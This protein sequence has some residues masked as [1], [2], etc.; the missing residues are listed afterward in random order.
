MVPPVIPPWTDFYTAD[1]LAAA[2]KIFQ[3]Y[4]DNDEYM[5]HARD[6]PDIANLFSL[7]RR[8]MLPTNEEFKDKRRRK[9]Q[10]KKEHDSEILA[11]AGIRQMRKVKMVGYLGGSVD[12]PMPPRI[13]T[14]EAN[15]A[16]AAE[17]DQKLIP[18]I[19]AV[20][21]VV[22]EDVQKENPIEEG[23]ADAKDGALPAPRRLMYHRSCHVCGTLFRDLHH[24]YDQMCPSCAEFNFKKRFSTADMHGRVC[25][26]TGARV[27]IGYAIALK[28]LRMG[29]TVLVTTRFPHDAA[30]RF[31][32][33]PDFEAFT[34]RLAVYGLDFRDIPMLHHFCRHVQERYSR[35]DVIIN[36]AAQTVRKPPAYYEHLIAGEAG[37]IS[38]QVRSIV[39]VVDVYRARHGG[40]VFGHGGGAALTSAEAAEVEA[41]TTTDGSPEKV[42]LGVALAA[43]Q[44][45]AHLQDVNV[46]AALSQLAV[47][48]SDTQVSKVQEFP[49]GL[50]DRDDQQL[51][52]RRENSW[53]MELGD[54]SSVEMMEC[55]VINTFAPWVLISE[56]KPLMARTGRLDGAVGDF[57]KFIVNVSAMEGQFYRN[58]TVFH[59][60]TNM[61]KAALNMMTRTASAG[62]AAINIFMTAV[63]TGWITD[64]NP[65]DQWHK[66]EQAPPPLDEWDAAM[67]VLDPVL[68]GVRGEEKLW[69]CFLKN[70]RSTRW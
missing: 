9:K 65:V 52:L 20:E 41:T 22:M 46:S 4:V 35:L 3:L 53:T 5:R 48:E 7:A 49:P 42:G 18:E 47:L 14:S 12:I 59:P 6:N 24:F 21:D 31:A 38:E 11:V 57:D 13:G 45:T 43:K 2:T 60:H 8:A 67:R 64:E 27:K 63:D 50:Y 15:E 30:N 36:N 55:H 1:E 56:L 23:G 32:R 29:A 25:I 51:D 68:V 10:A 28:L 34:G 39:D 33:E 54:I 37:G 58:K 66:R 61:A 16:F 40:Y 19:A 69:G 17:E 44:A 26:V 62:L 70:Y